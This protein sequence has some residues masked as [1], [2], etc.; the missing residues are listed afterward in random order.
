VSDLPPKRPPLDRA[1]LERDCDVEY[2]RGSGPGGQH[3]NKRETGIRL[4]HRASGVR[5]YATERRLRT[6][7]Q[8]LAYE[9]M[10]RKLD[11]LYT[12]KK[13]RVDTR[14]PRRQRRKRLDAKRR[15]SATK[16]SRR[17][18]HSDD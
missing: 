15:R 7:N 16:A 11:R 3:R 14:I 9:R 8:E 1:S 6:M 2:V 12:V 5:V 18:P 13:P 4:T 10:A 17:S